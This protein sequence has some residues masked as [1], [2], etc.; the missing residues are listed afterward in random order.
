MPQNG[1]HIDLVPCLL[2]RLGLVAICGCLFAL[3][4]Q[5]QTDSL[6]L[7]P[8]DTLRPQVDSLNLAPRDSLAPP[9][10]GAASFA[11]DSTIQDSL[12]PDSTETPANRVAERQ[13]QIKDSLQASS[14]LGSQVVYSASDSIVF[15]VR[16]NKLYLYRK[17]SLDY[18]D[19]NLKAEQ[20]EVD[21][22]RQ[23][24]F[25]QGKEQ[26]EG[27]R[28]GEPVFTQGEESYQARTMTYN[29]KSGKARV[30]RGRMVQQD[31]YVQAEVA[32]YQPDGS[33]HGADGKFTT[34]E[35]DD[36]HY[37]I[38]AK[39]LKVLASRKIITGPLR[40]VIGDFPLP[41]YL[42]FGFIPGNLSQKGKQRG[43]ITPQYGNAD[44]RGFFLRGLGYYWPV[45]D[46]FDLALEGDIYTRGGWRLGA[47]SNYRVRYRFSGSFNFQY[48][49]QRFNEPTDPDF[50]R[51]AAWSLRWNHN[52]PIDP[53]ARFNS[54][55]NISSSRQFRQVNVNDPGYFDN[56]IGSSLAFQKSFNNLPFSFNVS[57]QHRQDLSQNTV[58]VDLPSLTLNMNRL[59]PL[60]G[61]S[62]RNLTFLKQ[63][64][65]TYNMQARNSLA[66]IPDSLFLPIVQNF[67]DTLLFNTGT[68]ENPTFEPRTGRSFFRNGMQHNA[69]VSTTAKILDY[70]NLSPNFTYRENWYLETIRKTWDPD[71]QEVIERT[72]PGFARGYDFSASIS[73]NTNFYGIYQLIRTKRKVAFRQR[74]SP[75][76]GYSVRPDFSEERW[77][78]Y[79]DVQSNVE[80][81]LQR[82]S[83]FEDGIYGGPGRGESQAINFSLSSVL[84]MKYLKAEA[85]D[86]DFDEDEPFE[87]LTLI[88]N[89]SLSSAY[90]LAADSFQLSNFTLNART[91]LFN[92]KV[93]L[94]TSASLDPYVFGY[95]SVSEPFDQG[96]PR[97]F[98]RFLVNE[99][100][101]LGRLTR[102]QV[103]LSTSLQA[104]QDKARGD[105]ENFNEVQFQE[106]QRNYQKY[107]DFT[108]PWSI[109]LRY[110]LSYNKP[111]LESTITS[112]V[113]LSGDLRFGSKWKIQYTTGY[114]IV[115]QEFA[116]TTFS[117]FRDLHCWQLSF[118]WI[119]FGPR[120]SY[121]LVISAKSP[122][123]NALRINKNEFWTDVFQ[124]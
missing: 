99:T 101:Q 113:N 55:V 90:N 56:T 77:G 89:L 67:N 16:S 14:D 112:T 21:I 120:K 58:S 118:R 37:Y 11:A 57:G 38:E 52:Q 49:V 81:D 84:E 76:V 91:N 48:G 83:I 26:E 1:L 12:P 116:N 87:R 28:I 98:D 8:A 9:M 36:P 27:R 51:T 117:V 75:T 100:G 96:S 29:F 97:R 115:Q 39:K 95:K 68:L 18:D 42:P 20:V 10:D 88:D 64:G 78:F 30:T 61:L 6:A 22:K 92:R 121:S 47:S 123:L 34:C 2:R 82:Y 109:N 3:R 74:F 17:S 43:L 46:Y 122:T 15:D 35:L 111:G 63:L 86:P 119:P 93:S 54:S 106:A 33:F 114:D 85:M 59:S 70:I 94:N 53:T 104:K 19:F 23:E 124:N 66:T 50:S 31:I 105:T 110:N 44:D 5:A 40:P 24:L 7:A 4:V 71:S 13:R 107:V 73:A 25:A 80:G 32:K 102:A 72:L 60:R 79:R 65:I 45:S 41:I 69:S 103:S 108:I 62:G